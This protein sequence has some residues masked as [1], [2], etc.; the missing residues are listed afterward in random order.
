MTGEAKVNGGEAKVKGG[1][2]KIN[3]GGGGGGFRARMDHY[4]YSG[5]KKHV[6]VGIAII[7]VAF[8]IPWALKNRGSC[9]SFFFFNFVSLLQWTH[10]LVG[11]GIGV[12]EIKL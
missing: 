1:G 10:C 7:A 5:E 4:L 2:A 3:G 9:F 8:G 11:V 6:A 12:C